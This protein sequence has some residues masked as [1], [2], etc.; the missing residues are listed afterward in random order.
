M[1]RNFE[2]DIVIWGASGF[3]GQRVVH[4]MAARYGLGGDLRWAIGG[5]NPAKL[6]SVRSELGAAGKDIPIVTGDSHDVASLEALAARTKVVCS[7]VGPYAKYGSELVKACVSTGTHYC[8]ITGEIHWMRKMIDAHQAEAEK[9]GARIVHACGFDSVPSDMGVFYLQHKAKERHGIHCSHIKMRVKSMRGGFS[10]GTLASVINWTLEGARDPSIRR[11]MR[12]PYSLNPKGQ[13]QGPDR[14]Q[15]MSAVTVK[16]DEDLKGWTM[17]WFMSPMNTK[18]V[19][20]S[21]ALLGYPFGKDFRYDEAILVGSGPVGWVIATI[22]ALAVGGFMLALASPPTRWLLKKF[23]LPKPGQGPSQRVRERG[24]FD[25]ILVGKLGEGNVL[26]ARIKGEGDPGTES[27]SKLLVE[28]AVCLAQDSDRIAVG[29]GFWTPASAMGELLL[30][31]LAANA[32][33]SFELV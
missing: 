29:G 4:H 18:I 19:R 9:T 11:V 6:E 7:T 1:V 31:R 12:E 27:T 22:G 24:Y 3:V 30:S 2:F 25:L 32:A 10:G 16:Y 33:L 23:V 5:R 28:S 15:S 21:N 13:R 17:P 26:R 14:P 8:D 20:R